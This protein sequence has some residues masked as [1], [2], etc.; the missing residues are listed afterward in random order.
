MITVSIPSL[1]LA[2]GTPE[3]WTLHRAALEQYAGLPVRADS[4]STV[5]F[6]TVLANMHAAHAKIAEAAYKGAD[7]MWAVI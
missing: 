3:E 4:A 2:G 1:H 7:S 6:E 5:Q